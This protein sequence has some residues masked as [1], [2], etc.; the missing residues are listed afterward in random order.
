MSASPVS[1]SYVARASQFNSISHP[2]QVHPTP[3]F[4]N[5]TAL[6]LVLDRM[7]ELGLYLMYDMRWT[8]LNLTAVAE[9]VERIKSRPNLLLWYTADEPDGWADPKNGTVLAYDL[10]NELDQVG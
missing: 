7:E 10:I 6:E 8:Y 2:F 3:T 5:L 4:D 1:Q 9:E